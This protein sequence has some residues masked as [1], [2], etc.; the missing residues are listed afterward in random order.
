MYLAGNAIVWRSCGL[1][2]A[3]VRGCREGGGGEELKSADGVDH[4][5]GKIAANYELA[6]DV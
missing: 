2:S 5:A 1:S 6:L 4:S 3:S